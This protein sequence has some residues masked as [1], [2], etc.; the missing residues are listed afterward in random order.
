MYKPKGIMPPHITPF[1]KEGEIDEEGLRKDVDFWIEAGVHGLVSCGSNG[2][3]VYLNSQEREKVIKIVLD[4]A[5][6]RVPVIAGTGAPSTREAIEQT[7]MAKDLGVDAVLV[8]TPYFLCPSQNEILGYY[9]DLSEAVDVPIILYNVPKFTGVNMEPWVVAR[10]AELDNIVGIKDSSGDMKQMQSLINVAGEKISI[11]SGVGNLIFPCLASG[12][13]GGIVALANI[14]PKHC[15][16]IYRC[17]MNSDFA[18]ARKVQAALVELNDLVTRKYGVPAVK[19]ALDIIGQCGGYPR[20]P[21][22]PLNEYVREELRK[23]LVSLRLV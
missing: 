21:L 13:V 8:V 17:F 6:G 7:K 20:R 14:V 5:N 12:G 15:V 9:Q 3:A 18:G 1:T 10:L 16:E 19:A 23:L 11:L 2:E 4:Q 22:L